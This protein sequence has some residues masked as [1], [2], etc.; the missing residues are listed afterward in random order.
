[1]LPSSEHDISSLKQ[2]VSHTIKH[3]QP[4]RTVQFVLLFPSSLMTVYIFPLFLLADCKLR[5]SGS[6]A[7]S[8]QTVVLVKRRIW[9]NVEKIPR[10]YELVYTF[11]IFCTYI[12]VWG[13]FT[14]ESACHCINH[15]L[16]KHPNNLNLIFT[17][18]TNLWN[19]FRAAAPSCGQKV[20]YTMFI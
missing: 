3:T 2:E 8:L 17:D 13:F 20:C 12:S 16:K 10:E 4:S 9:A 7:E 5:P 18:A 6:F 11:Q 19:R 15:W 14:E 1:M